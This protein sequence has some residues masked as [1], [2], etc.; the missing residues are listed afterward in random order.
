MVGRRPRGPALDG[1]RLVQLTD[2]HISRLLAEP[3][4]RALVARIN[5]LEPDL[6]VFTGD[7][8]DGTP[9]ARHR[10][11][12][13]LAALRARHGVIA[14]LGNHEYYFGGARWA[15]EFEALGMRVLR[16]QHVAIEAKD[17]ALFVAGITD[18]AALLYGIEGPDLEQALNGVA[19]DVPLVLLSHRPIRSTRNARAGVDL[20]LSGH[21]HGG[22]VRGLDLAVWAVNGG[23]LS[24]AYDI[25]GMWMYVNRGAGL[26][27]GFPLRMGVPAEIAEI[28]LRSPVGV[29][30]ALP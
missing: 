17:H 27:N 15:A 11:V 4:T 30:P 24:G 16:N 19:A 13:P 10:D 6:I 18:P 9:A 21:T 28:V 5:A 1:F 20:Q 2:L 26:W 3:W 29:S 7:V 23:F 25:D 14:S 22:M 8:I 12:S